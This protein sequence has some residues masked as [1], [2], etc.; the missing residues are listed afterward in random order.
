[1]IVI[2]VSWIQ[3]KRDIIEGQRR[4]K[5]LRLFTILN[6]LFENM[7]HLPQVSMCMKWLLLFLWIWVLDM[8]RRKKSRKQASKKNWRQAYNYWTW[9]IWV[10]FVSKVMELIGLKK[11]GRKLIADWFGDVILANHSWVL[12]G[13]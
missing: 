3:V 10:L 7:Q 11:A 5:V 4:T 2:S 1:M 8:V 6:K 12:L 9:L 13:N